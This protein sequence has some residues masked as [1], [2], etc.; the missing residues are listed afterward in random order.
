MASGLLIALALLCY[1]GFALLALSQDRHWRHVVGGHVAGG[2]VH[3]PRRLVR[4]ARMAGYGLL[5]LALPLAVV[6]D[7][8]D[9]G[10]VLWA[11]MLS[12]GAIAVVATLTWRAAYLGP[13]VRALRGFT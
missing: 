8:P 13:L 10:A 5:A 2:H 1:V 12:A 7:G 11:T 6:R 9:F 4:P 3:C